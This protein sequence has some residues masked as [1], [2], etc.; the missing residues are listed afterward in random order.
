MRNWAQGQRGQ[1]C[2]SGVRQRAEDSRRGG[3]TGGVRA[4]ALLPDPGGGPSDFMDA[5]DG[6]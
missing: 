5:T 2:V 6:E 1:L 3:H 4:E